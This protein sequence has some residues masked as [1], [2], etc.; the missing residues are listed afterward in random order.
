MAKGY[1]RS[2]YSG[3][4]WKALT[5]K[6]TEPGC[7]ITI[8]YSKCGNMVTTGSTGRE[9]RIIATT[10]RVAKLGQERPPREN[11]WHEE[12]TNLKA[13]KVQ[14]ERYHKGYCPAICKSRRVAKPGQERPR[15]NNRFWMCNKNN[16]G[17]I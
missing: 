17:V 7:Q 12:G 5:G 10:G 1:Y 9:S 14:P 2:G 13:W 4:P 8:T 11:T 16:N 15:E 6:A 3:K